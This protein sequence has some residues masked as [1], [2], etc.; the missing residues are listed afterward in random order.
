MQ[1]ILH[2]G[3]LTKW[4]DDR[5]FGFIKPSD[6]SKEVFLH[7]SAITKSGRRP[8]V[9]DTIL[10][11]Q[12]TESSGKIRASRA[13]IQGIEMQRLPEKPK[14]SQKVSARHSIKPHNLIHV[15]LSVAGVSIG[16]FFAAE[17]LHRSYNITKPECTIKGNISVDTGKKWYHLP[18]M[19]DYATTMIDPAR[20]ERWFCSEAEAIANGWQKAPR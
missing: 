18:G 1:P 13:S 19:E 8:R 17:A 12:I 20:G 15:V 2:K 9:G 10:Y 16:L 4:N 5:G 7:I 6:G 11:E 14:A 3:Q